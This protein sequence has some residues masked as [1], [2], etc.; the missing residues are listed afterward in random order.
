MAARQKGRAGKVDRVCRER[1]L[2]LP[3]GAA[4]RARLPMSC[5]RPGHLVEGARPASRA[6]LPNLW[7]YVDV[8][9]VLSCVLHPFLFIG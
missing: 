2:L 9:S 4:S 3:P 5:A 1:T 6:R 7:C 8:S